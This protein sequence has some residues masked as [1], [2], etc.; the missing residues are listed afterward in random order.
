MEV[1]LKRKEKITVIGKSDLCTWYKG[2]TVY[3]CGHLWQVVKVDL[4]RN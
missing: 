1:T 2:D 4:Y 3:Y